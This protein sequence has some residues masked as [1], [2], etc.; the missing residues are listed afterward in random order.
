MILLLLYLLSTLILI[1]LS[2]LPYLESLLI[3]IGFCKIYGSL[4][5]VRRVVVLVLFFRRNT[6]RVKQFGY[7]TVFTRRSWTEGCL[8]HFRTTIF[9]FSGCPR[10]KEK[11]DIS[12]PILLLGGHNG[13]TNYCL[14]ALS[15][16][17]LGIAW[18]GR[19]WKSSAKKN[20]W[21]R[22]SPTNEWISRWIYIFRDKTTSMS[23]IRILSTERLLH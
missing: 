2:E 5:F 15:Q 7:Y 17:K 21:S 13:V 10:H 20:S 14:R 18:Q 4:L 22:W 8:S 12:F 9:F 23:A 11:R 16:P 1:I 19:V 3:V 6:N